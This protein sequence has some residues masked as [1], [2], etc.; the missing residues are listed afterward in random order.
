MGNP[1]YRNFVSSLSATG[2]QV[3]KTDRLLPVML[4]LPPGEIK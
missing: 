1:L 2:R 4:N 3:N